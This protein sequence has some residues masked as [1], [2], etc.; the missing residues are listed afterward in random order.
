MKDSPSLEKVEQRLTE[1][2][3]AHT[4]SSATL[5]TSEIPDELFRSI[6]DKK[7]GD[8]IFVRS[9][10]NGVFLSV[11]GEEFRPLEGDAAMSLARQLQ[12]QDLARAQ[13]SL[14][15]LTAGMEAKYQGD[16]AKIMGEHSELPNVTN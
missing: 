12:Q 7:P 2:G 11:K 9:G 10:Q 15:N 13:A 16:Y 8:V 6:Q 1:L 14:M 5:S 4:R 3:I